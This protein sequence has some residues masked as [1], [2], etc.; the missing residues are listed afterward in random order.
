MPS[1]NDILV[2]LDGVTQYPTDSSTVRSYS[3]I[4]STLTF[5]SAPD[6]GVAIQVRHIGFAGA[7][8]SAVT[9]FYGRQGNVALTGTDDVSVQNIS[10]VGATF[11]SN[12]NIEGVLT[13]EDVT[14]VDSIGIITARAGVLVGSGITLSKDGDG[15]FT[16]IVTATSYYG[17]GSNLSN[18]TST[19]INNNADNRLITGS[20]TA[21]TLN[22]ESTL[23]YDGTNLDLGDDKKIRVGASQDLEI[24]HSGT[25][26]RSY[27]QATGTNHDLSIA[28]DEIALTNSA[29]SEVL[30]KF[31]AN[32]AV[33]LYYDNSKK[34]HTQT[35]GVTVTG[36][37]QMDGTEAS[38][39]A[40]NIYIEDNGKTVY[41]NGSDLQI[42]HDGGNNRIL[43]GNAGTNDLKITNTGNFIVETSD[44]E[45]LLRGIKNGQVDL[46]YNGTK[47]FETTSAGVEITGKLT[48]AN[49]GL[50][51]GSIDL[52]ADADL[53]LYHDNS[54][55]YF[56]N[57]TGDF[58]IRNDGASTS[59][60]VRIQAKGGEQSIICSPNGAVELYHDNGKRLETFDLGI[61]I[62]LNATGN[63]G[64][65][66][67]GASY[68]YAN[69]WT[70]YGSGDIFLAGGLK[71]KTT[72]GGFFSSYGGNFSRNAIQIDAFGN[73]GIHFYASAAQNVAKDDAITVP[74]RVR[75][76]QHGLTFNGDSAAANALDD[77]EE[78]T[79]APMTSTLAEV[80][81]ARYTKIGNLV[82][83]N[84]CFEMKSGQARNYIELPFLPSNDGAGNNI[85]SNSQ[86]NNRYAGTVSFFDNGVNAVNLM[87]FHQGN[88]GSSA[89]FLSQSNN[90]TQTW[91][92]Q[93]ND[94]FGKVGVSFTYQTAA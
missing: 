17:D 23:T 63:Y 52:G 55:A 3:V 67:G 12:V 22:G 13:Y 46:Y 74:E 15:F 59:E 51:N 84:T 69:I 91:T 83:I 53:N 32:G 11:T 88:Q 49:D 45:N 61:D 85:G 5:V 4:E 76:N 90:G 92:R 75:I 80:Y 79:F 93:V 7:T 29:I 81:H 18:I 6:T 2:T 41:G 48:F 35:N 43:S 65:R 36:Y 42:Y 47:T 60:K 16:G 78:G 14:N 71:Q 70:E 40:G 38:A 94:D 77:Y 66:W 64:I 86:T 72:N 56:D 87:L 1:S 82:T 33:E 58:Y 44:S 21:N 54:D 34:L 73:E 24:Y 19:T 89:Y 8:T 62:G 68:N 9:G 10:G 26:N 50:A 31:I 57:N 37:I 39:A 25:Y 30:A 28:A 27:I 20:G